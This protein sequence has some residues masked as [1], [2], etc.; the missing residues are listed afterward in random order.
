[1]TTALRNPSCNL[2]LLQRIFIQ[3]LPKPSITE[4]RSSKAKHS[5]CKKTSM[6]NTV[7]SLGY[8]KCY[9]YTSPR[10]IKRPSNSIRYLC[11]NISSWARRHETILKIIKKTTFL[12]VM[13][14]SIIY[15][16]FKDFTNHRQ[17]T[18]KTL[19]FRHRPL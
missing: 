1:M 19:V 11:H 5:T 8:F 14:K 6:P 7:E 13:K 16:F 9:N 15:K 12:E 4:K 2:T 10:P 17:I 3:N 18:N